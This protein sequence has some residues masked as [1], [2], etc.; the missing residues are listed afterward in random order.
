MPR[1]LQ[2]V[3]SLLDPRG[4]CNRKGLLIIAS[5]MLGVELSLLGAFWAFDL[6]LVGAPASA[7][8]LLFCWLAITACSKRLHDLGRSAWN[9]AWALPVTIFWTL[10]IALA[11]AFGLGIESLMPRSPWY[12]LAIGASMLPVVSATLWLHLA[13]GNPGPNRFGPEPDG[14]GFSGPL[15]RRLADSSVATAQAT[16]AA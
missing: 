10:A 3:L 15:T 13:R 2:L 5:A 11:F 12:P 14:V 9:L 6:S 8:K 4:R 1:L 7:L 16:Q